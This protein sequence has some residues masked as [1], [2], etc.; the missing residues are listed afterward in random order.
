M[1]AL[2]SSSRLACLLGIA[3]NDPSG[4]RKV[5]PA[6][7]VAVAAILA[8]PLVRS[9]R[10]MMSPA[11][12]GA[13]DANVA[14]PACETLCC[15]LVP[16]PAYDPVPVARSVRS[17]SPAAGEPDFTRQRTTT[18]SNGATALGAL[19]VLSPVNAVHGVAQSVCVA[20]FVRSEPT[21]VAAW[22][23]AAGPS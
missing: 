1:S 16:T 6:V 8:P 9:S 11:L 3:Q 18:P 14:V 20:A 2:T 23:A 4:A 21:G 5:N 10:P 19:V 7:A 17:A 15:S 12:T 13:R 22:A